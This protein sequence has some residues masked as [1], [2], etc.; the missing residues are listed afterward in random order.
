MSAFTKTTNG[1]TGIRQAVEKKFSSGLAKRRDERAVEAILRELE[2][3]D[4]MTL[5]IEAAETMP[6][7]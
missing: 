6:P 1:R 7:P 2:Q 4:T 3:P 5:A